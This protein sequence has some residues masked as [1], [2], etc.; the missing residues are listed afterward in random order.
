MNV[1]Y[2]QRLLEQQTLHE[3]C[4][5]CSLSHDQ[6]SVKKTLYVICSNRHLHYDS[7]LMSFSKDFQAH[8][9]KFYIPIRDM[10]IFV[11]FTLLL[12][13]LISDVAGKESYT[14]QTI[15]NTKVSGLLSSTTKK[16]GFSLESIT[17]AKVF[18]EIATMID[19]QAYYLNSQPLRKIK[20]TYDNGKTLTFYQI[21]SLDIGSFSNAIFKGYLQFWSK[22]EFNLVL[23]IDCFKLYDIVELVTPLYKKVQN[24]SMQD[25]F[26]VLGDY[27]NEMDIS[28]HSK[29]NG[30]E[31]GEPQ[32]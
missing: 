22:N 24:G 27:T 8:I 6:S 7:T 32:F 29:P 2:L 28:L 10:A 9:G 31:T 1:Q 19:L 13:L 3:N 12:T 20:R 17:D 15:S 23:S 16:H 18:Q 30:K 14:D 11:V 25:F 4:V 21:D 5:A 26:K